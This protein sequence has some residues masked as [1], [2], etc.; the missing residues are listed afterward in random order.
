[1]TPPTSI[2]KNSQTPIHNTWKFH[3][4]TCT[5]GELHARE[6][7]TDTDEVMELTWEV[8]CKG[9]NRNPN[10]LIDLG[11]EVLSPLQANKAS[12]LDKILTEWRHAKNDCG[13]SCHW[14]T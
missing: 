10:R 11:A 5:D 9:R 3:L 1:M 14:N 13:R 6:L 8:I 12:D 7:Q 4:R 2:S